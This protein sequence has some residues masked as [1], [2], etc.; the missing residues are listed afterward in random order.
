MRLLLA[1]LL[2]LGSVH[3]ADDLSTLP[4]PELK[5]IV[6]KEAGQRTPGI[7]PFS[8]ELRG[9]LDELR[10]RVN[11]AP[12]GE[13]EELDKF[14]TRMWVLIKHGG[15]AG[16]RDWDERRA[17]AARGVIPLYWFFHERWSRQDQALDASAGEAARRPG[18]DRDRI[19]E[20]LL[21]A[22]KEAGRQFD[23]HARAVIYLADSP[24]ALA[25]A[26]E[27]EAS[28]TSFRPSDGSLVKITPEQEQLLEARADDIF[29]RLSLLKKLSPEELQKQIDALP[30]EEASR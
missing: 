19:I 29:R 25:L 22:K 21:L 3:A 28:L 2:G 11:A 10:R 15:F 30:A 12:A 7:T 16:Q 8:P 26:A 14:Q 5:A 23:V 9:G 1:F 6:E 20:E 18:A 4:L 13:R 27:A 24:E 17:M